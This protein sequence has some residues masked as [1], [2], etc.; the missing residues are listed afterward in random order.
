MLFHFQSKC[1]V[2]RVTVGLVW[3]LRSRLTKLFK[4][5]P[6]YSWALKRL[7]SSQDRRNR[8]SLIPLSDQR[9]PRLFRNRGG[10]V[11]TQLGTSSN[12]GSLK[13][14]NALKS[15]PTRQTSSKNFFRLLNLGRTVFVCFQLLFD[16][17]IFSSGSLKLFLNHFQN[18]KITFLILYSCV[19]LLSSYFYL[20]SKFIFCSFFDDFCLSFLVIPTSY[21]KKSQRLC[22]DLV[23]IVPRFHLKIHDNRKRIGNTIGSISSWILFSFQLVSL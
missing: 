16:F 23:R 4:N 21:L 3:S 22:L 15:F 17:K 10:V 18:Q 12:R 8:F 11:G 14:E 5:N 6:F 2:L 1:A 7:D 13:F 20:G 19:F 9:K